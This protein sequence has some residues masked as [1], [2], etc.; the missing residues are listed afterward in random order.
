MTP[1]IEA[2]RWL[3]D[4]LNWTGP[5][6]VLSLTVEHLAMTLAAVALAAL[7]ALPLGVWLGQ[8]RRAAQFGAGVIVFANVTRAIPTIALLMIFASTSIGFGNKPTVLAAAIF[9]LPVLLA[10]THAGLIGVAPDILDAARGTGMRQRTITT[11][12]ALP[13]A[14]PMILTGLRTATVQLIATIPL[15]ALVGGGGLG[16]IVI[17]GFGLQRFGQVIAGGILIAVLCLLIEG[18]LAFLERRTK[19]AYLRAS[20]RNQQPTAESLA[21]R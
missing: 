9:A 20:T 12:V 10:N 8:S 21:P 15:A 5:G 13:L 2:F 18:V 11:R 19:P 3:N 4:P 6:G 7:I 14:L 1:L 16:V 17:R